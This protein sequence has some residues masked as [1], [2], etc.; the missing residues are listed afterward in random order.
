MFYVSLLAWVGCISDSHELSKWFGDDIALR[1]DS[2][3]RRQGRP[4]ARALHGRP[5]RLRMRRRYAASRSWVGSWRAVTESRRLAL[6]S[7]IVRPPPTSRRPT[8]AV[9]ESVSGR[10]RSLVRAVG[11]DGSSRRASEA[12]RIDLADAHRADRRAMP[13]STNGCTGHGGPPRDGAV[14]AG[15]GVRSRSRRCV[16]RPRRRDLRRPRRRRRLGPRPRLDPPRR[17]SG[18]RRDATSAASRRSRTTRTSSRRGSSATP[19]ELAALAS[20]AAEVGLP[21]DEIRG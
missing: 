6:F 16:D 14:A 19:A 21:A 3:G 18:R 13:R 1:S 15:T 2:D 10:P 11:R 12:I 5:H 7:P 17:R 9:G 4:P 8:R 20:G